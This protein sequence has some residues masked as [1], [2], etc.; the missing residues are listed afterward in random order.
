[1]PSDHLESVFDA[2]EGKWQCYGV[3]S[4]FFIAIGMISSN[5]NQDLFKL[6]SNSSLFDFSIV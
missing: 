6:F 4:F 1:M 2:A 5:V 3:C